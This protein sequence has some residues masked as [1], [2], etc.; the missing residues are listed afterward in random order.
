MRRSYSR[1]A[2]TEEKKNI[3]KAVLYVILTISLIVLLVVLGIPSLAKMAAFLSDLR[4]SSQP[5]EKEDTTSPPPPRFETPSKYTNRE[6]IKIKGFGEPGSTIKIF[7]NNQTEEVVVNNEGY[8]IYDFKLHDGE[9]NISAVDVDESGNESSNSGSTTIFYDNEPPEIDIT[10]PED[11]KS[12]YGT[13]QRQITIEGTTK[14]TET[15]TING[16]IITI[17]SDNSFI[18]SVSLTE[19]ENNFDITAKD[20]AEN[21]VTKR[22]TVHFW[23]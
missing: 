13:K 16:R 17:R 3:R 14:D 1:L 15:L 2:R 10:T 23:R 9:N 6:I 18:Y 4:G 22:I 7:A 5:I 20:K 19:G 11:G 8:F 12:F 21:E